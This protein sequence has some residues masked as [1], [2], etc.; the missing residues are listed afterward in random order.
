MPLPFA[1]FPF[2]RLSAAMAAL[3]LM[4]GVGWSCKGETDRA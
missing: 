4:V 2:T 3:V 1:D